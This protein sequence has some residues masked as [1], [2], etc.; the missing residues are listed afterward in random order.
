MDLQ[1]IMYC[2][3]VRAG[4]G[5]NW[6]FAVDQYAKASSVLQSL[7]LAKSLVCGDDEDVLNVYWELILRENIKWN[8]FWCPY[9]IY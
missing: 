6:L 8:D 2:Y 1:D 5:R 4:G 9:K 3:G 7:R